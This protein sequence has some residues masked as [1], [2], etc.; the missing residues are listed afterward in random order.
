MDEILN[1]LTAR[2]ETGLSDPWTIDVLADKKSS[3]YRSIIGLEIE[4][5]GIQAK[6]KLSQHRPDEDS[7]RI[8]SQLQKSHDSRSREVA[9]LMSML[10]V[11]VDSGDI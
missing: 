8:V 2:H 4:V 5:T 7:C 9:R 3:L 11:D 1:Q 6:F 10:V